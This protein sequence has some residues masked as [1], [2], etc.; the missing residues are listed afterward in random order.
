[1]PLIEDALTLTVVVK[2]QCLAASLPLKLDC[3]VSYKE[4]HIPTTTSFVAIATFGSKKKLSMLKDKVG[5]AR[6]FS[7]TIFL[8][9][10]LGK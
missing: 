1:M 6:T 4:A 8:L 5:F 9:V 10:V 2:M 3:L 7:I